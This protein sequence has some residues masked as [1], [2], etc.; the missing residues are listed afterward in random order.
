VGGTGSGGGTNAKKSIQRPRSAE[1]SAAASGVQT[2]SNA[3]RSSTPK[4]RRVMDVS[5]NSHGSLVHLTARVHEDIG[6][7]QRC[8]RFKGPASPNMTMSQEV[9]ARFARPTRDP[10]EYRERRLSVYIVSREV[11]G[12]GNTVLDGGS[13]Q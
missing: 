13:R 7:W 8:Q 9:M 5:V 12:V 1:G 2:T 11:S 3:R 6:V 10:G 4:V